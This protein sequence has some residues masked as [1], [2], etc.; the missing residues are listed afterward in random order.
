MMT[1]RFQEENLLLDAAHASITSELQTVQNEKTQ[2][3]A[4]LDHLILKNN[5]FIQ[6]AQDAEKRTAV[7]KEL[8][9]STIARLKGEL[10]ASIQEKMSLLEEKERLQRQGYL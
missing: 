6:K 5:Q 2:L 3:Q 9:Q 4:H 7:Q 8:L 10:E 1:Q